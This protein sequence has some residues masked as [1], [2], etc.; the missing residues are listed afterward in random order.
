[1]HR[2]K[3]KR[4][5]NLS[6]FSFHS[7]A[8]LYNSWIT[9]LW[10]AERLSFDTHLWDFMEFGVCCR[11]IFRS[12]L[13][14]FLIELQQGLAWF[15]TS[16]TY[17]NYRRFSNLNIWVN[18]EERIS[19]YLPDSPVC[20][21][22]KCKVSNTYCLLTKISWDTHN[23]TEGGDLRNIMIRKIKEPFFVR[24]SNCMTK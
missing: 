24:I 2:G 19:F 10:M 9:P 18:L 22:V 16:Y 7:W 4:K 6:P 1:M 20:L 17:S 13:L 23:L 15:L 11:Q 21:C 14:C 12:F 8:A 3:G 5:G